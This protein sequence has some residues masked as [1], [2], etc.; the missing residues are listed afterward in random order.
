MSECIDSHGDAKLFPYYKPTEIIL[1][2]KSPMKAV[3]ILF[4][5]W[6]GLSQFIRMPNAL[7]N[8]PGNFQ[9]VM[10]VLRLNV[11]YN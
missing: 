6:P 2:K 9:Q 4:D 5:S 7:E 10:Y 8:A 1:T 11:K 3:K